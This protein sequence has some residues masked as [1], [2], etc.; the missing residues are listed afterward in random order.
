MSMLTVFASASLS[1]FSSKLEESSSPALRSLMS[2]LLS[3]TSMSLLLESTL[4][5]TVE[6][7]MPEVFNVF[8]SSLNVFSTSTSKVQDSPGFRF[9]HRT[10]SMS[11]PSGA[12]M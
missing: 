5:V 4:I 9:W 1:M 11:V 8:V 10:I 7:S 6:K 3:S 12:C 2:S